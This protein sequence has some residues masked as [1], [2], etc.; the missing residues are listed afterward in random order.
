MNGNAVGGFG[1]NVHIDAQDCPESLGRYVDD[2]RDEA[3]TNAKFVKL[4][5]EKKALVVAIKEIKVCGL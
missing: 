4:K 5:S 2:C 3:R 1:I